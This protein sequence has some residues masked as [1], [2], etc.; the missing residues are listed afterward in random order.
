MKV[1]IID[2]TSVSGPTALLYHALV[3]TTG[4]TARCIEAP[5]IFEAGFTRYA[6]ETFHDV[7]S[8]ARGF[9]PDWVILTLQG[10]NTLPQVDLAIAIHKNTPAA[11]LYFI[12]GSPH[13]EELD[14]A[15][16]QGLNFHFESMPVNPEKLI[17]DLL[18][19]AS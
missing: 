9:N 13:T 3:E 11:R 1:L 8:M 18:Q 10:R 5:L 15:R 7:E 14:Y 19:P 16:Q 12:S 4:H 17:N 6:P 2:D